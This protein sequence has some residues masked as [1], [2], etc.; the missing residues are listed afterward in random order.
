MIIWINGAFGS[1]KTQTAHELHRRIT[2]SFIYDPE[3]VGYFIQKNTPTTTKLNDFQDYPM[4]R[5]I[6][7]SM[8]KYLN[9][10]FKGTIIV[11]M[12]IVNP[13]YFSELVG[14]LRTEGITVNH[15]ALCASEEVLLKRLR[16]RGE[17]RT[18]WAAQQIKRCL[19]G[20]SNEV[21]GYHLDTNIMSIEDV[22]EQIA[23]KLDI[24]LLPDNRG[25]IRRKF[26]KVITQLSY[27][28]FIK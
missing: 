10:N 24:K 14:L 22:V 3:N 13:Q 11:P 21:F 25:S 12:T 17:G 20:L 23:N 8:L 27:I 26:D 15:F 19:E 4:W 5:E 16:S 6:N 9:N 7:Y 18:S 2:N 28:R 1:G